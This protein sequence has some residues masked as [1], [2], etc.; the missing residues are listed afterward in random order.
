MRRRIVSK[1]IG[2]KKGK[3]TK[4]GRNQKSKRRIKTIAGGSGLFDT[5]SE[6]LGNLIGD[7]TTETKENPSLGSKKES[8]PEENTTS[9][10]EPEP[11]PEPKE[12]EETPPE[13]ESQPEP[14]EPEEK[15]AEPEEEEEPPELIEIGNCIEQNEKLVS[16]GLAQPI[17]EKNRTEYLEFINDNTIKST[18][19][20]SKFIREN[21]RQW[22]SLVKDN[23]FDLL[24][25]QCL[26]NE[27][28]NAFKK[29]YGINIGDIDLN[30]KNE[31]PEEPQEQ[32]SKEPVGGGRRRSQR[33]TKLASR[34]RRTQRNRNAKKSKTVSNRKSKRKV[35]KKYKKYRN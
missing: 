33:K 6:N 14:K 12:P 10:T 23:K 34:R 25:L 11:E 18:D 32:E 7:K 8:E 24:N 1:K 31:E 26:I 21:L 15:P 19:D 35:S 9:T 4:R 30:P 13:P 27:R 5:L 3:K 28:K 17:D 2:G 20:L 29:E 22:K 16:Q